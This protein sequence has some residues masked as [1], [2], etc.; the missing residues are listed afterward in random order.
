MSKYLVFS[1]PYFSIFGLNTKNSLQI[2][3]NTDQKK[4]PHLDIFQAV[5]ES[6][7]LYI[8]SN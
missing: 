6:M 8:I 4:N 1:G 5:K 2:Q 7:S 3:E